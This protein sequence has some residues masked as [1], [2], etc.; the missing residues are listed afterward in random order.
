MAVIHE[1]AFAE[2]FEAAYTEE[3]L[4]DCASLDDSISA[5]SSV[6][7]LSLGP[8]PSQRYQLNRSLS[9]GPGAAPRKAPCTPACMAVQSRE[10]RCLLSDSWSE[11]FG[12]TWYASFAN[13]DL[14]ECFGAV[15]E[16]N[17]RF[18]IQRADMAC[19][20]GRHGR[21]GEPG[22]CRR[23]RQSLAES[24]ATDGAA[25]GQLRVS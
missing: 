11:A 8:D 16:V 15:M 4:L 6:H 23:G 25:E 2:M 13:Q 24:T 22:G 19:V 18:G 1:Q 9:I 17:A 21:A 3:E 12:S 5:S 20:R 10:T 7:L 14:P